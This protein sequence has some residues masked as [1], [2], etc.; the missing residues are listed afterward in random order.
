ML[1]LKI[2]FGGAY[3]KFV[4]DI[5]RIFQN[6]YFIFGIL[7]GILRSVKIHK[8]IGN[9][10]D[11]WGLR[12]PLDMKCAN[13]LIQ[14]RKIQSASLDQSSR[15]EAGKLVQTS[16]TSTHHRN[17][18]SMGNPADPKIG[19]LVSIVISVMAAFD[20]PLK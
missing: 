8:S 4:K 7:F 15:I 14:S 9:Q 20:V 19:P 3:L 12:T 1:L 18:L 10:Q 17:P 11:V 13:K 16:I 5:T 2:S 6:S